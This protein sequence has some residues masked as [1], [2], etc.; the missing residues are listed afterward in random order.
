MRAAEPTDLRLVDGLLSFDGRVVEAFG[1][2]YESSLRVHI[3]TVK[4]VDFDGG[5][6]KISAGPG[7]DLVVSIGEDEAKRGEVENLVEQIRR[8]AP[9]WR[10]GEDG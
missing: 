9:Y 7:S 8:S 2:G 6:L 1:F 10:R 3:W 4:R 5:E